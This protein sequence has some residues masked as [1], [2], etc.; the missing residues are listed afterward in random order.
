MEET[1]SEL[2]STQ[3][4]VVN[5][6]QQLVTECTNQVPATQP[7]YS[8]PDPPTP[9]PN[10]LQSHPTQSIQLCVDSG[11]GRQ[12]VSTRYGFNRLVTESTDQ[13]QPALNSLLHISQLQ[14]LPITNQH[15]ESPTTGLK[16]M[17][18]LIMYSP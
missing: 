17:T 4:I 1:H 14:S 3:K 7:L 2:N 10:W 12:L 16:L 5:L 18:G 13:P 8:L 6:L 11:A 9:P 15:Q